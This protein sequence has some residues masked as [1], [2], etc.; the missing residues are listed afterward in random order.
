[1]FKPNVKELVEKRDFEG[2]IKALYYRWDPN[3]RGESAW[4]IGKV[5]YKGA[6]ESLI[7]ALKDK[8]RDVR[9]RAVI[10]LGKIRDY[11]DGGGAGALVTH[12]RGFVSE[13]GMV[14]CMRKRKVKI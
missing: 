3:I 8:E 1:M 6:V 11:S 10:A 9:A 2:L 12:Q 4:A 13:E 5:R 7:N 14:L